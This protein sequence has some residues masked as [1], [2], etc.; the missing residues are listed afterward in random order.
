MS[1]LTFTKMAKYKLLVRNALQVVQVCGRGERMKYGRNES[2]NVEIN[3]YNYVVVDHDGNIAALTN[4]GGQYCDND[5]D[6]VVDATGCCLLP[7]LIDS[8]THP[9]W[10]GDRVQEFVMKLAGATY[11]EIHKAGGGIYFTVEQ[12]R[13]SSEDD[14]YETF[15]TRL[16]SMI[17]H[18]TTLVECKSG[19]GL[20]LETEMK[21]LRVIE[22]ARND[23]RINIDIS[24]TFCGAHAVP[25]GSSAEEATRDVIEKQIPRIAA[26]QEAGNLR[27]DNIDV[28]CEKGVFS[29]DQSRRILEAGRERGGWK[30]NFHGDELNPIGGAEV[31]A[32]L[33]AH[34]I[35]HLEE[36][37]EA[38]ILA[39][40]KSKSVAIILP[41]TAYI[42][43]LKNPPVRAMI[44]AGVPVA[45]GTD[46]NPNAYCLSMPAVMH[47]ACVNFHMSL[48]EALVAATINSAA[49]LGK[50]QTHGSIE[51]GKRANFILLRANRWE[52]LVYRLAS[53]DDIIE[54]VI[55]GGVVAN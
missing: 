33:G 52:H 30:M 6:E 28:F 1:K 11:M 25:K 48:N 9:V 8:H 36:I 26:E 29:C 7:G 21:M 51:V 34:G 14:L 55:C 19:Y 46:F 16:K 32:E 44:D 37:S 13:A 2:N 4:D 47:L 49:S 31:G 20:D 43:R 38:G 3:H 18:G 41:T 54:T 10:A 22:R 17:R 35:S 12:T 27:V 24:T 45:L 15:V 50:G 42:L 40:A 53:H 23:V 39:M 5:F